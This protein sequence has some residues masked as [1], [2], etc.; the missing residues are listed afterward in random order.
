MHS[1]DTR[2]Q[3]R[4]II[5]LVN[6]YVNLVLNICVPNFSV[7]TSCRTNE[8]LSRPAP[9]VAVLLQSVAFV[10]YRLTELTSSM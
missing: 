8:Q 9:G 3:K 7:R 2:G 6:D 4:S 5:L 10:W 1:G